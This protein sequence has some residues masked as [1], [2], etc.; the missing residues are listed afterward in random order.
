LP[1]IN[2]PEG[3]LELDELALQPDRDDEPMTMLSTASIQDEQTRYYNSWHR[4]PTVVQMVLSPV[5]VAA[6]VTSKDNRRE[7]T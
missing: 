6:V 2:L 3:E 7:K 1:V 4:I 5:C